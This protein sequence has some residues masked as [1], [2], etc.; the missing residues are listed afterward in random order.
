MIKIL[1]FLVFIL[2][3]GIATS[4]FCNSDIPSNI[5]KQNDEII[6]TVSIASSSPKIAKINA[7][8]SLKDSLLYMDG[9]AQH[10]PDR[11]ATFV[12]NLEVTNTFGEA[13]KTEKLKG[14]Q[15]K[16]HTSSGERINLTYEVKLDHEDH[17]WSGGIDGIAY[18]KEWGVFYTGRSLFVMNG[19]DRARILVHFILPKDWKA[20]TPWEFLGD[21]NTSFIVS[22]LTELTQSMFF[23]GSHYEFSIK[24]DDFELIF[25]LGGEQIISDK[26]EFEALAEGVFDYYIQLMGGIPNPAPENKFKKVV[27][28]INPANVTDGE[29]VGNS[30]SILIEENGDQ[31]SEMISRF[32]FAHEFFHL[33]NGKSFTPVNEDMEWFKEG[34]TNYYTLKSLH[35]VGFL[36]DQSFLAVLNNLFYQRYINDTGV[37][38]LSMSN[39]AEKHGH[40][41]LIYGGGLFVGISQDMIIRK[42]TG[43]KKSIDDLMRQLYKKYGGT[44]EY[45]TLVELQQLMSELSGIE[46][47]NFFNEYVKGVKEIPIADY[48]N[49]IGFDAK[50]NNQQLVI[51]K[52]EPLTPLQQ[53]FIDGFYGK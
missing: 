14:A 10:L 12:N 21:N 46:Q 22:S 25:A 15:W 18:A 16:I 6:Y 9:G 7:S 35:H 47:T 26:N 48:L 41:G 34:F 30:I 11:W 49:S 20:T 40:W 19:E 24:R 5:I 45:Y 53:S 51:S 17:E 29:V 44:N 8:F 32:I 38:K 50:I 3:F 31:M 13:I 28:I 43:N 39:G 27:V 42:A 37:G 33:W 23:A 2:S 52:K 1:H 36:N 4:S